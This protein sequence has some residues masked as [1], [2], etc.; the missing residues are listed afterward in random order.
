MIWKEFRALLPAWI[1]AAFAILASRWFGAWF[2]WLGLF[3]YVIAATTL[4][5]LAFGHEYTHRTLPMLLSQPLSRNR[6]FLAKLGVLFALLCAL[7]VVGAAAPTGRTFPPF[8]DLALWLPPVL[9]LCLAPWLTLVT[10]TPVA[11]TVFS[12]ALPGIALIAGEQ[13]G[14]SRYGYS[15]EVDAFRVAFVWW[16]MLSLSAIGLALSWRTFVRLQAIEGRGAHVHVI[17]AVTRGEASRAPSARHPVLR[18]IAKELHLQQLSLVVA[19]IYIAGAGV[20]AVIGVLSGTRRGIEDSMFGL[21]TMLYAGLLAMMIGSLASAEERHL[22]T[23]QCQTLLPMSSVK[24]W[25]IKVAFA[26]SLALLLG[27]VVPL[28][29]AY[30]MPAARPGPWM[31]WQLL[32]PQTVALLGVLVVLVTASMYVSSLSPSGV[33]ALVGS[34][35]AFF[36]V[37]T[38]LNV[39]RWAVIG[40]LPYAYFQRAWHIAR[41]EADVVFFLLIGALLVLTLRF[42]LLNHRSDERGWRHA[43]PQIASLIGGVAALG[44]ARGLLGV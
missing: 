42:A 28:T 7:R 2:Q 21:M 34:C 37:V 27:V 30:V 17:G 8:V 14:V 20:I 13:L 5:A 39:V 44:A 3:A 41:F 25:T 24:Q 1:A 33:W 32:S 9:A 15:R 29:L 31:D 35:A 40:T 16:T 36:A 23:L 43:V 12:L 4:G 11:G 26:V 22:G 19:G 10:R 6:I 38:L 18:L